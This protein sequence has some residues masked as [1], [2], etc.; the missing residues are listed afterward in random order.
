MGHLRRWWRVLACPWARITPILFGKAAYRVGR[1]QGCPKRNVCRY[2]WFRRGV[3]QGV[4]DE[5]RSSVDDAPAVSGLLDAY[6]E[7]NWDVHKVEVF[8]RIRP[9][10]YA[11]GPGDRGRYADR[12][13]TQLGR[14]AAIRP[15]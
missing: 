6:R 13:T 2:R 5:A 9:E 11:L 15:R 1:Q 10:A 8:G 12:W 14:H 7:I 3:S 4:C